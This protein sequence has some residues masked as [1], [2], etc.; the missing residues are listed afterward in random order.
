MFGCCLF[1][2]CSILMVEREGE[3][4]HERDEEDK[5]WDELGEEKLRTGCIVREKN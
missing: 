2:A 5:S 3:W 1:E 4:I